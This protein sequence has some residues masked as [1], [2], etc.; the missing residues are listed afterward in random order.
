MRYG[1]FVVMLSLLLD[2]GPARAQSPGV[3]PAP[4][5]TETKPAIGHVKRKP[6]AAKPAPAKAAD[7]KLPPAKPAAVKQAETKPAEI[8]L[9]VAKPIEA[10]SAPKPA[11]IKPA[12]PEK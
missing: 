2:A 5:P 8:K 7:V 9:P 1:A 12:T 3:I 11:A 4:A 6:V 10:K